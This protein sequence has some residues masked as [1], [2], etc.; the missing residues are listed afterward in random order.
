MSEKTYSQ[1][2]LEQMD[3]D[4]LDKLAFGYNDGDIVEIDP[5]LLVI[6]YPCD[7]ENPEYCFQK[8][9]MDWV[10]SVSLDEPIDVSIGDDGRM[11][12]EDGHHRCFAA[13]KLGK[14]LQAKVEIKGNPL[15]IILA[16]QEASEVKKS[17]PPRK[18]EDSSPAP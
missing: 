17:R 5:S 4:V 3:I 11:Y 12:L 10:R 14:K 1:R 13:S 15:R 16:R 9:G 18:P 8:G 7:L 2:E 6:K